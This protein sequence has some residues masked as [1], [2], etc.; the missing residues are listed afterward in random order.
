MTSPLLDYFGNIEIIHL[1]HRY[2]RYVL[3]EKELKAIGIFMDDPRLIIAEAPIVSDRYGFPSN[4]VYGNFLSHLDILKRARDNNSRYILV[5]ED[6]AIFRSSLRQVENQKKLIDQL[7]DTDWDMLFL[8]HPLREQLASHNSG[9]IETPLEFKWAHCYAVSAK[10]L[11]KLI[12]YL[13]ASA[14]RPAGHPE[15]GKMYIDGAINLYRRQ[16]I[17]LSTYIHNPALSI[18]RGS[19][20]GIAM[21]RWYDSVK[22]LSP[23]VNLVR[24]IRDQIWRFSGKLGAR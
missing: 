2:D 10:A 21:Q 17:N 6:D 14:D 8:G 22:L 3:L 1:R 23:M 7:A 4:Q 16:T 5:L 19:P 20:S 11:P 18:Q 13:E 15:G 12:D 9:F 24:H